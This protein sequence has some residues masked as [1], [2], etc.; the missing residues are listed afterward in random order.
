MRRFLPN[1]PLKGEVRMVP[2]WMRNRVYGN[3]VLQFCPTYS[4]PR[5]TNS[6]SKHIFFN[7]WKH[8][9][10]FYHFNLSFVSNS[11][12]TNS[13]QLKVAAFRLIPFDSFK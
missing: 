4:V 12:A 13:Y 8:G 5:S 1:M 9:I 6:K 3:G 11:P 10:N 2:G 7:Q